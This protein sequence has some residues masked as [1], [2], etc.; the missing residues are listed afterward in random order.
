MNNAV[1]ALLANQERKKL[2][3][4][5]IENDRF[6][7]EVRNESPYIPY[8]EIG[9]FFAKDYSQKGENR[10]LGLYNVRQICDEYGLEIA[11]NNVDIDG[12]NWLSFEIRKEGVVGK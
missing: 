8:K 6:Y 11:C 7:I 5:V 2:H 1:E 3:V 10:G 12:E 9:T 4:C